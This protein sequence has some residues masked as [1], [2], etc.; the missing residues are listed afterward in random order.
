MTPKSKREEIQFHNLWTLKKLSLCFQRSRRGEETFS[1]VLSPFNT[2][3][4]L[5]LP[6]PPLHTHTQTHK[7][8][9]A[10]EAFSI[11]S[12]IPFGR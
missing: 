12:K 6:P 1:D 7:P 8:P 3:V 4:A 11:L 10:L 2:W 9:I 5:S